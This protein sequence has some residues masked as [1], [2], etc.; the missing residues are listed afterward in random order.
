MPHSPP[1]HPAP[2]DEHHPLFDTHAHLAEDEFAGQGEEVLRRAR[3]AGICSCLCVGVSA[4]SS[5]KAVEFAEKHGL[6][7]AVG[8]HPNHAAEAT[9][10]DWEAILALAKHPRV[11][12]IGETGLDYYRRYSPPELQ[13]EYLRRHVHLAC[14]SGLPMILHCR[15]A[16]EDILRQLRSFAGGNTLHGV[17]HAFSGD[18]RFADECLALGLHLGFAGNVTY[19]NKKFDVLRSVARTVPA[20][21]LLLETDCPYLIPQALRGRRER[22]EPAY[23]LYTAAFLAELRGAPLEQLALTTTANAQ[24]MFLPQSAERLPTPPPLSLAGQDSQQSI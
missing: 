17:L 14:A 13:Q 3:A 10:S 7:A 6:P 23:L 8:I 21:R 18:Q 2:T 24:R 4:E 15:D 1:K 5:R 19:A 12:A 11:A 9:N 22:N 16:Q 20:N